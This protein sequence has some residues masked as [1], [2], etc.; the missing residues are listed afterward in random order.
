MQADHLYNLL[1]V[2]YR[3]RDVEQGY[4]LQALLRV[5]AE[6]A[7]AV[8]GDIAQLYENWFI[9]TCDDWVTPYI[10]DLV[11]W[12]QVHE[13]G[14][15][16]AAGSARGLARNKILIPRRELANTI[17]SRRRKGSLAL[18]EL[19]A[20]DVAGWPARAVEFFKLLGWTQNVNFQHPHRGR[21]VDARDGAALDLIDGPFD[22]LAH[23]VDARRIDSHRAIGRYN[24]PSVGLF[25]CRLRS[26]SIT[27]APAF[28][29]EAVGPHLFTF[30]V[31][32]NDAP[33]FTRPERET[34]PSSIAGEM[35]LPIPIR[36]R[37]FELRK[38]QN[39]IVKTQASEAYYGGGKSVA[40]WTRKEKK[41]RGDAAQLQLIPASRVIPADLSDWNYHPARG[42]VAVDPA[43][44]RIAFPPSQFPKSGVWVSYYYG[45]SADIGGGEY[46]RPLSQPAEYKL[47]RVGSGE[48]F[49]NINAALRQ[50]TDQDSS[51]HPHAVIEIADSGV[52]AEQ[53]YVQLAADQSLQLRARV[54]AR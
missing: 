22:E 51:E 32:G 48:E 26:Y 42:Y 19:L 35:D 47:Y 2:I 36:R 16:G 10:G 39:G 17:R 33:L 37:A 49:P 14:E 43:L 46:D 38:A 3:L 7:D 29:A 27:R 9:E 24:I 11:G 28:C 25:V 45:F 20:N 30:S 13:A 40:I 41:G 44:G 31:L 15:P 8:E 54:G 18:L 53:L 34:D 50:W 23:T 12:R 6:Q 21:T 4:P 52:Y 1:P 5:I